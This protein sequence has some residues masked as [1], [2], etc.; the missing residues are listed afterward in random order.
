MI[1]GEGGWD[2]LTVDPE[3]R[4]V[5][6]SHGT[7]TVVFDLN[8][9]KIIGDISD[10]KG[11]H[12]IAIAT[13]LGRGFTSNGQANTVTVFD[14][15]TLKTISTINVPGQ[16]PD[17]ILYDPAT[18]RVFTFNGRS[19]DAT[20]F[21][22]ATGQLVGTVQLPG[23]LETAVLDGKGNIFVNVEDKNSLVEL[24]S[25]TLAVKHTYSLAPCEAPTGLA[26]DT[27]HRRL[28]VGCGDNKMLAVVDADTGKVIAT[29][30]IGEH[31]DAEDFD[32]ANGVI[33]ASCRDGV[34][35]IIHEDSPDKY[36]IVANINTEPG[37]RTSALDPTTHH[38]F[39]VTSDFL[40]PE[41]TKE[42]PKPRV[43][44]V[45]GTFRILELGE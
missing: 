22:A 9:N 25:Q 30:P 2:Y 21:D 19:H 44:S 24:D 32:S 38:V 17:D 45:P 12:G 42:N 11:V 35:N 36:T 8:Q 10:T 14:L 3:A 29:P 18:K 41:P 15:G 4:R 31:T 40:T 27:T 37:A 23:K 1:G 6:I 28:F 39:V 26:M 43:K 5:Y 13:D 33:F 34:L 16:N 20:A 7:H